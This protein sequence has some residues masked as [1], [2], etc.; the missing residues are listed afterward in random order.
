MFLQKSLHGY[1]R[2]SP[3][4]EEHQQVGMVSG[5]GMLIST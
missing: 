3:R 1:V 5:L 4:I 2:V